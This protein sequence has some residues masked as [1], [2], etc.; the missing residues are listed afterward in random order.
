MLEDGAVY[1]VKSEPLFYIKIRAKN[2]GLKA[3]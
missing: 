1:F 3:E 2:K